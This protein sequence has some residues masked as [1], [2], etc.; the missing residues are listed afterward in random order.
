MVRRSH[1]GLRFRFRE[2]Q[3]LR[4][5]YFK[6]EI[7]ESHG[8]VLPEVHRGGGDIVVHLL[9]VRQTVTPTKVSLTQPV[10]TSR[11]VPGSPR[12]TNIGVLLSGE[13]PR[14]T[15]NT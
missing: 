10:K 11:E 6:T 15:V 14:N 5:R 12:I 9:T 2:S 13:I 3:V 4:K 8:P 1:R 7:T